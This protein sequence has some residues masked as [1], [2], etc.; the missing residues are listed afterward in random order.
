M[1]GPR[2]GGWVERGFDLD[3]ESSPPR[4]LAVIGAN[5]NDFD[6]VFLGVRGHQFLG[7][8]VDVF[9]FPSGRVP[10]VSVGRESGLRVR[11][12]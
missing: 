11:S 10:A 3:A 9:V 8:G 4:P 5:R 12:P 1:L 6:P 7:C 2:I